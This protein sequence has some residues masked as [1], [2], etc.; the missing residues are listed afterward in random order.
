MPYCTPADIE[1]D[2][3]DKQFLSG[4]GNVTLENVTQFIVEADALINAYVGTVYV[5]PVAS[6]AGLDLL[7]LL[8]R[9]IASLR[10]KKIME[11][12]QQVTTDANQNVLSVL[13]P[14][15]QVMKILNDIQAQNSALSGA[16]PLGSNGGFRNNNVV[17][18]VCPVLKKDERQW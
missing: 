2:F 14:M 1:A 17:N 4:S 8:S 12:V 15:P 16:V 10:I 13:L 18:N 7:K 5:T 6:G 3:K 11:V 9:S